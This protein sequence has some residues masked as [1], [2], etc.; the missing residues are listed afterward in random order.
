MFE[1][2]QLIDFGQ[3]R[4][5]ERFGDYVVERLSP[6][7]GISPTRGRTQV[8]VSWDGA[9]WRGE[10]DATWRMATPWFT[11]GLRLASG[12]Q[13]GVFPEQFQNW[14]YIFERAIQA[15]RPL[16]VLN[17]FAYTGASSLAAAAVGSHVQ[18]THLD[19][20][21]PN[22]NWARQN[23]A[24]NGFEHI[25][26]MVDDVMTFLQRE[27]KRGNQYDMVIADPPAFGRGPKGRWQ[28]HRDFDGLLDAI[29]RV[30]SDN[31]VAVILSGHDQKLPRA[32][33]RR[34]A[35]ACLAPLKIESAPLD[36]VAEDRKLYASDCVRLTW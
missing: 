29:G 14:H 21:K 25:R 1:H 17:C 35:I 5:W 4:K 32:E 23:A 36:L 3:G 15:D 6:Q 24:L 20:A 18:V 9:Q 16:K 26:W 7:A 22:V 10:V 12:G 8:D 28:L 13:V 11:L 30:L 33:M 34:R 19:G 2:Y 31:P 27:A